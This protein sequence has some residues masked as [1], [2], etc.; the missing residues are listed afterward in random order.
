PAP[1]YPP[2]PPPPAGQLQTSVIKLTLAKHSQSDYANYE[3]VSQNQQMLSSFR[4][5]PDPAAEPQPPPP[6]KP[7]VT[8]AAPKAP[9]PPPG[10]QPK[11][12][13][14]MK[15]VKQPNTSSQTTSL[16][17][18]QDTIEKLEEQLSGANKPH[19]PEPDY[20]SDEDQDI[21]RNR[22]MS[23]FKANNQTMSA[24]TSGSPAAA[25]A[26]GGR[27]TQSFAEKLPKSATNSAAT[28]GATGQVLAF[29]DE[30]RAQT[31]RIKSKSMANQSTNESIERS[32][33]GDS[34]KGSDAN[35]NKSNDN[36][37]SDSN[38]G[39]NVSKVRKNIREFE[40]RSSICG[41]TIV[42]P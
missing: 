40:R 18:R 39:T 7:Q 31:E 21:Q 23:T 36:S 42:P 24:D 26:S 20:D 2:P 9:A 1:T 5:A 29:G 11:Q 12:T 38:S 15:P 41:D 32:V 30:L 25:N 13:V 33:G 37:L 10:S 35:D 3:T 16:Y 4:P 19:I 14:P 27:M 8:G 34:R 17:T 28:T 22:D 6:P